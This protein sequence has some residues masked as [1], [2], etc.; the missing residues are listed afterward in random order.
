MDNDVFSEYVDETKT[1]TLNGIE[2]KIAVKTKDAGKFFLALKGLDE[3][4]EAQ[5][6]KITDLALKFLKAGNP[7]MDVKEINKLVMYSFVE[8]IKE[9]SIALGFATRDAFEQQTKK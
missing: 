9:L 1:I 3:N 7:T 4:N 5:V 8:V 6:D 2:L